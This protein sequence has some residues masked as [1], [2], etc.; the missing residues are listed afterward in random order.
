MPELQLFKKM[1]I[2]YHV[3]LKKTQRVRHTKEGVE[4]FLLYMYKWH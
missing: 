1:C 2:T 4:F 3:H